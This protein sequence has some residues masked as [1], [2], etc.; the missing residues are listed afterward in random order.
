M[1]IKKAVKIKKSCEN[2]FD[3]DKRYNLKSI[4]VNECK[5]I[6]KDAAW[7]SVDWIEN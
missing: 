7:R 6:S 4:K 2:L 1:K 5:N 3:F